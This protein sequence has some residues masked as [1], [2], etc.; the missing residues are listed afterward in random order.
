MFDINALK[1]AK[2]QASVNQDKKKEEYEDIYNDAMRLVSD[3]ANN[4]DV[5]ILKEAA[6]KFGECIQLKSNLPGPYYNLA[7]IF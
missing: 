3:F 6:D 7:A 1:E 5:N 4:N 2:K